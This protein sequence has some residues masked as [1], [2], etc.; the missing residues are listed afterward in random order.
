MRFT[1]QRENMLK[2][3]Q[4]V[5]GVVEKRQTLPVLSN[6]LLTAKDN[7]LALTATDLEVEIVASTQL[8]IADKGEVTIPAR[9]FVDICRALPEEAQ[10]E[11]M[12]DA[13]KDRVMIRSGKSRFTLST[14]PV[15]DFPNIENVSGALE[16][17][18]PQRVLKLL[19][20]KT[21]FSMAQQDVRYYLNGL[22]LEVSDQVVKTVAT[23]GHRLSYCEQDV[24]VSPAQRQQVILPRKGV[25]E[26]AKIL[27]D[28][29]EEAQVII[30]SN[31]IR[32]NVEGIQFTSKLIDGQFPDY[33]RVIPKNG[34]KE[35]VADRHLLRQ[36][37]VRTSIL[38]NE[39]YRGIRLRLQSGLLQAQAHNPEMEEAEE[40]VE[41]NYQGSELEIGFNVNYL[42]DALA[43]INSN[44]VKMIYGDANSS[45]LIVSEESSDG[46]KYVV[47]PMRL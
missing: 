33:D 6:V 46:C 40:E 21:Q 2:P 25:M 37:L 47:M 43:V 12:F 30:G 9:K 18:V 19:I 3:L 45:C 11:V 13:D 15:K 8:D 10:M 39:K 23:D 4:F 1:I 7:T 35:V 14:L 42:L 41:V 26:L 38:S 5:V 20:D 44:N 32:V 31:H 28:S 24:D 22:L 17:S 34:D 29:E 16:F 27:E 36:A